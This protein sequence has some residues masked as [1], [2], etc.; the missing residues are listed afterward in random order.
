MHFP[1]WDKVQAEVFG[2]MGGVG[3]AGRAVLG[4]SFG[5]RGLSLRC[6]GISFVSA[7]GLSSCDSPA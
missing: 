1:S 5:S 7:P 2:F 3:Q 4:L 6:A